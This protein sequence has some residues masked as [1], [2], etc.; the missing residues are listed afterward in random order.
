MLTGFSNAAVS[1]GEEMILSL[2]STLG[3]LTWSISNFF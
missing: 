2:Q 1:K 3:Q